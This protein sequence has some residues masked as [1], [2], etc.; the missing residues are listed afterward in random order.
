MSELP[1]GRKPLPW[2]D[3]PFAER[4]KAHPSTERLEIDKLKERVAQLEV[5]LS[6][7][8]QD[9]TEY[10]DYEYPQQYRQRYP[11]IARRHQRDLD[12]VFRI[13]AALKGKDDG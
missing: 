6:E 3:M 12:L 11:D 9:L 13:R 8:A 2:K 4:P 7:A 10:V 1:E 5:L